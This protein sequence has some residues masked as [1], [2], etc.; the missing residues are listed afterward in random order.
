MDAQQKPVEYS[1]SGV[2]QFF[3][4]GVKKGHKFLHKPASFS[5][6]FA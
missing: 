2:L 1:L 3:K 6:R 4:A 5:W